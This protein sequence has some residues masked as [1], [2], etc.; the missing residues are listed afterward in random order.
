[1][2]NYVEHIDLPYDKN[3]LISEGQSLEFKPLNLLRNIILGLIMFLRGYRVGLVMRKP[4]RL[5]G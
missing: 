1:M 2:N 4:L 3:L 5:L